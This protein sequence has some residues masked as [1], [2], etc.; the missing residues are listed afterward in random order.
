MPCLHGEEVERQNPPR[1]G[2]EELAPR[3][4]APAGGG[5]E[6]VPTKDRADGG[7][8]NPDVELQQLSSDPEVAPPGVL[9]GQ[10]NDEFHRLRIERRPARP[11][12]A[13]RPLPP[14][15]RPVPPEQG[16]RGHDERPPSVPRQGPARRGEQHPV[17]RA[18]ERPASAPREHLD[19]I[20]EDQQLGF[21]FQVSSP[22]GS[23][24]Q[25]TRRTTKYMSESSI[26]VPPGSGT[27]SAMQAQNPLLMMGVTISAPLRFTACVSGVPVERQAGLGEL[28]PG[29]RCSRASLLRLLF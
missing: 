1:L 7:G 8:G 15:E 25:S 21:P 24:A 20:P 28:P 17:P 11:A 22:F 10:S 4:A 5:A 18:E 14:N 27:K 26:G 19:L 12:V 2:L 13:I 16:P 23:S 6:T 29:G 9:P 3:G